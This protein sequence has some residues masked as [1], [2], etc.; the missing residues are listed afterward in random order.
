MSKQEMLS[1]YLIRLGDTSLMMGQRLAEWCSRGPI[2]EEDLALTNISLDY[3]GQAEAFY[4][5]AIKAGELE[6]SADDLAFRRNEREYTNYILAE[7]ENGDFAQTQMKIYLISSFLEKLYATLINSS[8]ELLTS[9]ARKA[10]KEVTYHHRHSKMWLF[11]MAHGTLESSSRIQNGL[12]SLWRYTE[13]LFQTNEYDN[14]WMEEIQTNIATL[15]EEWLKE[16]KGFFQE[17][18]L[19]LPED[20]YMITGGIQKMH[21]EALGH[22]LCEMQYLQR[23]YPEATW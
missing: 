23:A 9:V 22:L 1:K 15:K 8:E 10:V 21:T 5:Q 19:S 20:T 11:R 4:N 2:L 7:V 14:F 6:K 3:F 16:I 12:N 18:K 17:C 13:D